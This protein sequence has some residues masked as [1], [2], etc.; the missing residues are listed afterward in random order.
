MHT[1]AESELRQPVEP[2]S[3]LYLDSQP[4][5]LCF[6]T[7]P[8]KRPSTTLDTLPTAPFCL[9]DPVL[10][11]ISH[12]CRSE[13]EQTRPDQR[14]FRNLRSSLFRPPRPLILASPNPQGE[15]ETLSRMLCHTKRLFWQKAASGMWPYAML[16]IIYRSNSVPLR[17]L[18]WS[19]IFGN[20]MSL[21][22]IDIVHKASASSSSH[23]YSNLTNASHASTAAWS[24]PFLHPRLYFPPHLR[25]N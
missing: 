14:C 11:Y 3:E 21:L 6:P 19:V 10:R 23:K 7:Q 25:M 24:I 1:R 17:S 18:P 8:E 5:P 20:V 2:Q 13:H 15:L 9:Q 16:I 12:P 4:L 22:Y